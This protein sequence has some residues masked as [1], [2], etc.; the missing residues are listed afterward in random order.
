MCTQSSKKNLDKRL[1]V[2]VHKVLWCN[3]FYKRNGYVLG[4]VLFPSKSF[5]HEREVKGFRCGCGP[6]S[7]CKRYPDHSWRFNSR[8]LILLVEGQQYNHNR[9]SIE[10]NHNFLQPHHSSCNKSIK[11]YTS[12]FSTKAFETGNNK[13]GNSNVSCMQDTTS[14][15]TAS[16]P[17]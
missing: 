15:T 10:E 3:T 16:S 2:F 1:L 4:L 14:W 17:L 11:D 5:E 8:S 13:S 12:I 7:R 6:W 9:S